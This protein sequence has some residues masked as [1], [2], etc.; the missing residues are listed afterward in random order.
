MIDTNQ[1]TCPNGKQVFQLQFEGVAEYLPCG[2]CQE[3]LHA[4]KCSLE[5]L[6]QR[7]GFTSRSAFMPLLVK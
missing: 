1:T 5:E 6:P 3:L 7:C 4:G 2:I